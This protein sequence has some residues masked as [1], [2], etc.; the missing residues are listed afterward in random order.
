[1]SWF[2]RGI[3]SGIRTEP[4]SPDAPVLAGATPGFPRETRFES[5][6]DARDNETRCPTGAIRADGEVAR[7]KRDRCI[8]CM[9]C[10][11]PDGSA[12]ME[13]TVDHEWAHGGEGSGSLP[14][15]F[16]R[17]LHVRVIDA[18]DCGACLNEIGHLDDPFY[19]THRFGIFVT[20]TPRQ[21]D[22]LLIVGPVTQQMQAALKVAYEAMPGPRRVVAVGACAVD[23]GLFGPS[24]MCGSG[25]ADVVPVDVFVP[26]CPPPPLA[27]LHALRAVCGQEPLER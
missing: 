6:A 8:H 10:A 14:A 5:V 13:W 7:V 1:M 9:R 27:I 26:G 19:N 2:L 11:T 16:R 4:L 21:A 15:A 20:P 24:V 25:A 12:K 3:R 18:G 17:S 23:G 22:V